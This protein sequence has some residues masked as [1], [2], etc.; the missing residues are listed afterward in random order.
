MEDEAYMQMALDLAERGR[1][2]VNPNPMVGAVIVKDGRV[3]GSGYHRRYGE[4]HAE[5]NAL[6]DC[7]EDTRGATMYVTLEPCCHYGKTPPCTEA[8]VEAGISRVV[9][10]A[11]DVNPMVAG[12]GA[13]FL[14][15]HGIEVVTG[16]LQEACEHLNKVFFYHMRSGMP[17]VVLKYA[18]TL[19]GKIATRTGAS[20][21]ITGEAARTRVHQTRHELM[22]IMVGSGT[23]N[24]DDPHLDCRMAEGRNPVRIICDTG[25][26]ISTE[27]YVVQTAKT[28]PTIIAT[29][30]EDRKRHAMYQAYGCEI[31]HIPKKGAHLDVKALMQA[32]GERNIDSI[33]LEGGGK[34]AWSALEAGVVNEIQ[35]Y[36]A[37][38]LFGGEAAKT[39]VTGRGV[40]LPQEAVSLCNVAVQQIGEDILVNADVEQRGV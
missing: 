22:G 16:V 28:Q 36:I 35:A 8:I 37:P 1:G 34:L 7:K 25:L 19:D 14:R 5:R 6:A 26:K 15:N 40:D 9:I 18:M 4:L 32:L 2:W 10:G 21:W 13:A 30:C 12:K 3:I 17:Y 33:L 23:V 27:S 29:S 39:P 24:A 20:K 38:K 31:L 11:M